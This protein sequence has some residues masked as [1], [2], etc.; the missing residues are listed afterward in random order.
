MTDLKKLRFFLLDIYK[1]SVTI[2]HGHLCFARSYLIF[3]LLKIMV[4]IQNYLP[5]PR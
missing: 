5:P 1:T 2:A 4:A 3:D